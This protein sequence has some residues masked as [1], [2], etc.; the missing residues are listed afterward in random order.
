[1]DTLSLPSEEKKKIGEI[2]K[3]NYMSSEVSDG[4][5][6][7]DDTAEKRDSSSSEIGPRKRK[8]KTLEWESKK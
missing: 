7:Q 4:D 5:S 1:M 2:L 3:V 8:V 6:S